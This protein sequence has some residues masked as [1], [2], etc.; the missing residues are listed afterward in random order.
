MRPTEIK[1]ETKGILPIIIVLIALIGTATGYAIYAEC[2]ADQF[3]IPYGYTGKV[4]VTYDQQHKEAVECKGE[5]RQFYIPNN[6]V[7]ATQCSYQKSKVAQ[8]YFLMPDSTL[9]PI[10]Q[11]RTW[12]SAGMMMA[13]TMDTFFVGDM[14]VQYVDS[15]KVNQVVFT[16][17]RNL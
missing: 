10:S 12:G 17:V 3:I 2:N 4:T 13:A 1:K 8:F 5:E 15:L 9:E 7:L 16:V 6:G 14:T 11:G